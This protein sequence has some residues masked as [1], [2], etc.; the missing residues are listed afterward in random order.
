MFWVLAHLA[1]LM[2]NL[3][4]QFRRLSKLQTLRQ[5]AQL[6]DYFQFNF[7]FVLFYSVSDLQENIESVV[8]ASTEG[9]LIPK[10]QEIHTCEDL[11]PVHLTHL[12]FLDSVHE[13]NVNDKHR[14]DQS[15]SLIFEPPSMF[16]GSDSENETSLLDSSESHSSHVITD[17]DE[18]LFNDLMS[19]VV[20]SEP[21]STPKSSHSLSLD[22]RD[23]QTLQSLLDGSQDSISEPDDATSLGT[24]QLSPP[25]QFAVYEDENL[26]PKASHC[27]NLQLGMVDD[28]SSNLASSGNQFHSVA[29]ESSRNLFPEIPVLSTIARHFR[30]ETLK[31][32]SSVV[33]SHSYTSQ[34]RRRIIHQR[35][36]SRSS[37]NSPEVSPKRE[38][39]DKKGPI[40]SKTKR[41]PSFTKGSIS[42]VG[43]ISTTRND[44]SL[45]DS[46][47]PILE[48]NTPESEFTL[49]AGSPGTATSVDIPSTGNPNE[50]MSFD[51][52]LHSYD[53]YASVT[54]KTARSK[55]KEKKQQS[56][57][58]NMSKKGSKKKK[59]RRRSMTVANI[60]AATVL[61]AREAMVSHAF[62]TPDP[63]RR[64]ISRVQQ[65]ARE[66]SRRIKEHQKSGWFKRFSTVTEECPEED[67]EEEPSWLK[68]L[69]D[70]RRS[71]G[72]SQESNDLTPPIP[73]KQ[74]ESGMPVESQLQMWPHDSKRSSGRLNPGQSS[75]ALMADHVTSDDLSKQLLRSQST[76]F[77]LDRID[78]PDP[79]ELQR[80]G[81]L[82]GWVKSVVV[83]FGGKK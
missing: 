82:K 60:D 69:R 9:D 25:T 11:E 32:P 36:G 31:K 41:R 4:G 7:S 53:H 80:K 55:A 70:K 44:L 15:D 18:S 75:T 5:R 47:H 37:G 73:N 23:A 16:H 42:V 62:A 21:C 65:L 13:E 33:R 74:D 78:T 3:R 57:S 27:T 59:D 8:I 34:H 10:S 30:K 58:P 46:Y 40:S 28:L 72:S 56:Q 66:Y 77:E 20:D 71:E 50:E 19:N 76:D 24:P 52:A 51:E 63:P 38:R 2:N 49:R 81:G 22:Q 43:L 54:G 45:E 1:Y 79:L 29:A 26:T 61:A 35:E 64:K 39:K 6:V 67:L 48:H 17:Y 83:K 12:D 14:K 68:T